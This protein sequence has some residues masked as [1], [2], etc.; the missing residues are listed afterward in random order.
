MPWLKQRN[1]LSHL[2]ADTKSAIV[3]ILKRNDPSFDDTVAPS[4]EKKGKSG[5]CYLCLN[6]I[7]KTL[8][9]VERKRKQKNLNLILFCCPVCEFAVYPKP[10]RRW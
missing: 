5:K 4:I 3:D 8:K 1:R 9:G 7:K 10:E 6:A 2:K